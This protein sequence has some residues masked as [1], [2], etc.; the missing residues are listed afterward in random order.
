MATKR[1]AIDE[2]PRRNRMKATTKQPKD[3]DCDEGEMEIDDA[4]VA[5][6]NRKLGLA[7]PRAITTASAMKKREAERR[8]NEGR[9]ESRLTDELSPTSLVRA[10]RALTCPAPTAG[11]CGFSPGL[12]P[13]AAGDIR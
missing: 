5:D 4:V 8:A 2:R 3:N 9:E 6:L 7:R 11:G 10:S 12:G 13:R 1:D